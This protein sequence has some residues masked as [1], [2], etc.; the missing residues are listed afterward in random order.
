M[1][2]SRVVSAQ[3]LLNE[4][5]VNIAPDGRPLNQ[6]GPQRISFCDDPSHDGRGDGNG[7]KFIDDA[8]TDEKEE[9]QSDEP[10]HAH[11]GFCASKPVLF[12]KGM[13]A[14]KQVS[15]FGIHVYTS[16]QPPLLSSRWKLDCPIALGGQSA[17]TPQ[18]QMSL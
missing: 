11:D 12:F 5:P 3:I 7:I 10:K 15:K 14:Q 8:E 17:A 6:S 18:F 4:L 2:S 16:P 9:S 1:L 13:P